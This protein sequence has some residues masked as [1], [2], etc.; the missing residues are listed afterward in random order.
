MNRLI[1]RSWG[2]YFVNIVLDLFINIS[3]CSSLIFPCA[4]G[5]KPTDDREDRDR[6]GATASEEV[7]TYSYEWFS[8]LKA[9]PIFLYC[10]RA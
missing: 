3:H 1:H 4:L 7:M 5:R 2:K 9:C 8:D 10:P 6:G